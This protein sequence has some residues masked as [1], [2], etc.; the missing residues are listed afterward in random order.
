MSEPSFLLRSPDVIEGIGL[1]RRRAL[2][3]AGIHTIAD[4]FAARAPRVHALLAGTSPRQVGKWFCAATLLRVDGMT[5]DLAEVLVEAGIRSVG[6][7][8]DAPL[9]TVESAC[10]DGV[11]AGRIS[12][13]PS[14]YELADLQ[15]AAWSVRDHGMLAGRL[16]D[17][18]Q[19]PIAGAKVRLGSWTETTDAAGRY[20][21]GALPEGVFAAS[22]EI[23]GRPGPLGLARVTVRAGKL[24]GPVTSRI[25]PAPSNRPPREFNEFDGEVIVNTART[26]TH[27][28][29]LPLDT[30]RD[31]T[32]FLTRE[33]RSNGS[34]RLLS[35]YKRRIGTAIYIDRAVVPPADLPANTAVGDVLQY[36]GGRL[37]KTTLTTADVE[38]LK[39]DE[40]RQ[41]HPTTERRVL[42]V[43]NGG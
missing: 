19:A 17:D 30:F 29:T 5:P 25:P 43:D 32:Y 3:N 28:D 35:L 15:R 16:V 18:A 20:A 41:A 27:L 26:S 23:A 14:L 8:A 10:D 22:I 13:A 12:A 21:F 39:R 9:Q 11:A 42:T 33:F 31:G 1:Q 38:Q 6:K 4:L 34:A 2:E 7:L 36:A 40:R 24:S 37:Q